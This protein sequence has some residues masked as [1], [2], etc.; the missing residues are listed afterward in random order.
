[1]TLTLDISDDLNP[2]EA[3]EL[4]EIAKEER[5]TVGG[6]ILDA[7]RD[8]ARRRREEREALARELVKTAA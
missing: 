4:V 7:A 8:L 2:E 6:L 1:M 5:R 3:S